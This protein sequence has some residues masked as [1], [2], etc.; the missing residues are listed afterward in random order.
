MYLAMRVVSLMHCIA[1]KPNMSMRILIL[2]AGKG[3][4]RR[5][6]IFTLLQK[7]AIQVQVQ[8]PQYV[9]NRVKSKNIY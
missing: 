9:V 1:D 3:I 7:S 2:A 5:Q 4:Q 6:T 8:E